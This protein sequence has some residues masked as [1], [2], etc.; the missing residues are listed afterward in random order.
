[1]EQ[2]EELHVRQLDVWTERVMDVEAAA[3]QD[4]SC[5]EKYQNCTALGQQV[6]ILEGQGGRMEEHV[7]GICRSTMCDEKQ[8]PSSN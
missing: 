3:A 6:A 7:C 8:M 1:M 5:C 4:K 2:R